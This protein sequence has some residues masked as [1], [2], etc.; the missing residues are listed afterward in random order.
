MLIYLSRLSPVLINPLLYPKSLAICLDTYDHPTCGVFQGR[1]ESFSRQEEGLMCPPVEDDGTG[2]KVYLLDRPAAAPLEQVRRW[3]YAAI[4]WDI[5][6]YLE[7]PYVYDILLE[8]N[9]GSEW[10][11]SIPGQF[12]MLLPDYHAGAGEKY[13]CTSSA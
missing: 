6:G 7:R 9:P 8:E 5:G 4:G 13:L 1:H 11:V 2:S 3:H 10:S 12:T